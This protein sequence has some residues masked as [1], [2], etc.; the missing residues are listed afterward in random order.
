MKNNKMYQ[1]SAS[2]TTLIDQFEGAT[3]FFAT[4]SCETIRASYYI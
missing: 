4:T 1:L 2:R 3:F